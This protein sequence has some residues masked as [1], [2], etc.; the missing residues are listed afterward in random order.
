MEVLNMDAP[1]TNNSFRMLTAL[2]QV[3]DAIRPRRTVLEEVDP[4]PG[5]TVLDY[6]CG[7]GGYTIPAAEAV[8]AR[9]S[10]Y[11]ADIHPLALERVQRL[12]EGRRLHN[13]R[14][15]RTDCDTGLPDESVDVVMFY[16]ILHDLSE[17][18]RV[19]TELHRVLCPGGTLS[20]SD[21]HLG[22]EGVIPIVTRRGRFRLARR[23]ERTLT[24]VKNGVDS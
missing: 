16:D 21:H 9:G 20:V 22:A 3:R 24:F 15:I 14:T 8:G 2:F 23:G 12:A 10:V 1:M 4:A 18:G 7:P 11:A 6:G 17:P 5:Q 13:V 19:L